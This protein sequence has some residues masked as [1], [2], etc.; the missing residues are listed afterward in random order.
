MKGQFEKE[1][2]IRNYEEHYSQILTDIGI[3][4]EKLSSLKK[5]IGDNI[6]KK[7][8]I[9]DYLRDKTMQLDL[10]IKTYNETQNKITQ[11]KS[12]FEQACSRAK[13]EIEKNIAD[14]IIQLTLHS[15]E[16][17]RLDQEKHNLIDDIKNLLKDKENLIVSKE[18]LSR[19]VASLR[20]SINS[21]I[22]S[23]TVE[24]N[25][26]E[27]DIENYKASK[28]NIER[29]IQLTKET[30]IELGKEVEKKAEFIK[31]GQE[32][33]KEREVRLL[34]READ[35]KVVE[36]RLARKHKELYPE[37]EFKL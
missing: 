4:V 10:V 5:E 23:S 17:K 26:I 6:L 15:R 8:V 9:D 22:D 11:E 7:A 28:Q 14:S 33:L 34:K 1:I 36:R 37:L 29:E 35:F 24:R 3:A 30:L 19:D 21:V 27:K 31:N 13:E 32:I 2:K 20:D 25:A 16:F 12:Q 18:V